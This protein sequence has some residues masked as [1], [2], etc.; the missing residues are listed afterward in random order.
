MMRMRENGAHAQCSAV[1]GTLSR[2]VTVLSLWMWR[3]KMKCG[4]YYEA[5]WRTRKERR[6]NRGLVSFIS[7]TGFD[8]RDEIGLCLPF[9]PLCV[10]V[11]SRFDCV[12]A[13]LVRLK[14]KA[15]LINIRCVSENRSCCCSSSSHML[16]PIW[17]RS[18]KEIS[19]NGPWSGF[20]DIW[21]N[22]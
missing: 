12:N 22:Q 17:Q 4:W 14:I 8:L 13:F 16:K 5:R 15:A 7:H 10:C 19:F 3:I 20:N 2:E 11:V 6:S 9:L 1:G 21:V 18:E